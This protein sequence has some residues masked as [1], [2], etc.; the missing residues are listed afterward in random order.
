MEGG[1]VAQPR[2]AQTSAVFPQP[3]HTAGSLL[4]PPRIHRR[5]VA[6]GPVMPGQLHSY[7]DTV[8]ENRPAFEPPVCP[9]IRFNSMLPEREL[10]PA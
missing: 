7:P 9:S 3:L 4:R 10:V 2:F 8:P 6:A 5:P 1:T